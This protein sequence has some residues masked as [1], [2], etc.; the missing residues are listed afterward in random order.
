MYT[1]ARSFIDALGGYR[2][3]AARLRMSA[4]TLHGYTVGGSLPA[5]WY[6]ALLALASERGLEPPPRGLFSFEDLPPK[7][8]QPEEDAA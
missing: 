2:A 5:K 1:N 7:P 3:V 6:G 4:T 8:V